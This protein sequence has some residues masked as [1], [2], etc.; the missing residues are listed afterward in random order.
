[1]P[2]SLGELQ[3]ML[4]DQVS[5]L[6]SSCENY[7]NGLHWEAMRIAT[8]VYVIVNNGKN[9]GVS[10]LSQIGVRDKLG[11]VSYC[12]GPLPVSGNTVPQS[13][14]TYLKFDGRG[15]AEYKPICYSANERTKILP[16]NDWW[17]EPIFD[18]ANGGT[19][20]RL[21][22]V[23]YLRSQDGGSHYDTELSSAIYANFKRFGLGVPIVNIDGAVAASMRTIAHE[24]L[25][26]LADGGLVDCTE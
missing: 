24:L 14:L 11:F 12:R 9:K 26:T 7:D 10:V 5:A 6:I 16:F 20:S 21:D 18:D 25:R 19:L 23:F 13:H 22:L 8:T 1:M 17:R 2:R 3:N 4:A 15:G